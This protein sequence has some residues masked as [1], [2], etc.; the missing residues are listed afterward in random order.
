VSRIV[1][2]AN[3]TDFIHK[4]TDQLKEYKPTD[5]QDNISEKPFKV[6]AD[7]KKISLFICD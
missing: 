2:L 3:N 1:F 6:N 7:L 4:H 5:K